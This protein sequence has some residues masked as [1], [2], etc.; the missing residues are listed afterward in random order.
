MLLLCSAAPLLGLSIDPLR[1]IFT[2]PP[3]KNA[4]AEIRLTNDKQTS[5]EVK[6]S[7]NDFSRNKETSSEWVSFSFKD[8]EENTVV[9]LDA[10]SI[11]INPGESKRLLCKV[12]VPQEATGELRG[13]LAFTEM[14]PASASVAGPMAIQTRISIPFSV[15]IEGTE[16]Y[17]L[18]IHSIR[19]NPG[20]PEYLEVILENKGNVHI[21]PKGKCTL[22]R[23]GEGRVIAKYDINQNGNPI[24]PGQKIP[25]SAIKVPTSLLA[26][27]DYNAHVQLT[28]KDEEDIYTKDLIL[29]VP[30]APLSEMP[31]PEDKSPEE[32]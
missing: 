26:S 10:Q 30:E 8:M 3:G 27:G 23:Q 6:V 4:I 18:E 22:S 31:T 32:N 15:F 13:R 2:M 17:D 20:K 12:V 29:H 5:V 7:F 19:L 24:Y 1:P 28:L 11:A 25:L 14:P 21:R 9:D 16:T